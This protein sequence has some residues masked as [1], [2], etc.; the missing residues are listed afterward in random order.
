MP[1]KTTVLVHAQRK[2]SGEWITYFGVQS[3]EEADEIVS[4]HTEHGN[5]TEIEIKIQGDY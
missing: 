5:Y 2:G 3:M 1:I 4:M